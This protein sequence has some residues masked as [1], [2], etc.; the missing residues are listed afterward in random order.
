MRGSPGAGVWVASSLGFLNGPSPQGKV[1]T[2]SYDCD[3]IDKK[4]L[5]SATSS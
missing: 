1:S 3:L 2:K 5:C 4:G